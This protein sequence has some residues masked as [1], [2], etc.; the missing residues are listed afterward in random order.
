MMTWLSGLLVAP[1]YIKTIES[2][3]L[4]VPP[5]VLPRSVAYSDELALLEPV[6]TH[7]APDV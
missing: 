1:F 2:L 5:N 6:G 3:P 7:L 4:L